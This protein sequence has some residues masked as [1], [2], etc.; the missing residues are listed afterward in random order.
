VHFGIE[1]F[2]WLV[3]VKATLRVVNVMLSVGWLQHQP[4]YAFHD[5]S[6]P[7]LNRVLVIVI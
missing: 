7:V 6:T 1:A 2:W 4:S 5:V 3:A